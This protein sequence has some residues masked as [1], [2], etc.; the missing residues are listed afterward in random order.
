MIS[1]KFGFRA[2]HLAGRGEYLLFLRKKISDCPT[3]IANGQQRAAKNKKHK[4]FSAFIKRKQP[5][6]KFIP[7]SEMKWSKTVVGT[8]RSS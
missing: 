3:K 8:R 7:P 4:Y 6:T 1:K 5:Y 2:L